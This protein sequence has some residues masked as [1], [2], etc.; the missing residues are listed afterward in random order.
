MGRP[1]VDRELMIQVLII[2]YSMG[3]RSERRLCEEFTSISP[4][5]GFAGSDWAVEFLITQRSRRTDTGRFSRRE[6]LVASAFRERGA[7]L[8][9]RGGKPSADGLPSTPA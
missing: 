5:A 4:I 9:C 8:H 6:R 7:T 3:I 2:G 1:S